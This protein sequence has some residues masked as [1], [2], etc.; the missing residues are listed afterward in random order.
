MSNTNEMTVEFSSLPINESFARM[1]VAAFVARTN[2]TL[3]EVSDIK[4]AV[5]EAVTNSIIHGYEK[6]SGSIRIMST[7]ENREV[8][9]EVAD[10]GVGIFDVKKAMEPMFST[11]EADD[12]SG[13]GF[14]FMEAFMD[15][16]VVESTPGEGT[17]VKMW[18]E[19]G[20]S[21]HPFE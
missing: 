3:E 9:I 13:M 6:E 8:Y 20:V 11:K 17:V 16:L 1:V 2:P 4:M 5:S 14:S 18:K 12:R 10:K 19:I 21:K 15:K 7:V